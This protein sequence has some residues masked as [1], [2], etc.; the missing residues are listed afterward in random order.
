MNEGEKEEVCKWI[1]QDLRF[2]EKVLKMIDEGEA[3]VY[4]LNNWEK[5][6]VW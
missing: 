3:N 2:I 4:T 1:K 6:G 5:I